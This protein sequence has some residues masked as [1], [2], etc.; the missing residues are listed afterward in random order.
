MANNQPNPNISCR[1]TWVDLHLFRGE[2]EI[3]LPQFFQR[4]L[5]LHSA[6]PEQRLDIFKFKVYIPYDSTYR[7]GHPHGRVATFADIRRAPANFMIFYFSYCS[8]FASQAQKATFMTA[9]RSAL[10]PARPHGGS[11]LGRDFLPAAKVFSDAVDYTK[12]HLGPQ[13]QPSCKPYLLAIKLAQVGGL[14]IFVE[15]NLTVQFRCR[16]KQSRWTACRMNKGHD[17]HGN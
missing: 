7:C 16:T 3:T 13:V 9:R 4:F 14:K 10:T 1:H 5:R 15:L 12:Y 2:M 17:S 11:D 6:S 8:K